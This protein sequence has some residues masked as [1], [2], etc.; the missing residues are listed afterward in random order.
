MDK[1]K[2]NSLEQTVKESLLDQYKQGYRDGFHR[3][4][5]TISKMVFDKLT[6]KTVPWLQ[7]I[8]DAAHFCRIGMKMLE[9]ESQVSDNKGV[10]DEVITGQHDDSIGG[11]SSEGSE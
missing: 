8:Q 4:A 7:R 1:N 3:G 9:D 2:D 6:N 10:Q 11:E 5:Y